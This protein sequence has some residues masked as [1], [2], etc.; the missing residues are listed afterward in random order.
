MRGRK[1][2]RRL[3]RRV[4]EWLDLPAIGMIGTRTKIVRRHD[5][6]SGPAFHRPGSQNGR[7]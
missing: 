6:K 2:S 7:K 1:L 5:G 3:E 4:K